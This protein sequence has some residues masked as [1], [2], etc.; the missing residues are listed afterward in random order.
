MRERMNKTCGKCAL[1]EPMNG[2]A[3]F[4]YDDVFGWCGC[5]LPLWVEEL[6]YLSNIRVSDRKIRRIDQNAEMCD[7]YEGE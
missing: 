2:Q 3:S 7:M 6:Y 4:N 5:P 1:L